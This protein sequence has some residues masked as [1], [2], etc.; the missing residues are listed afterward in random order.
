MLDSVL[1][2]VYGPGI[3]A[4]LGWVVQE[5]PAFAGMLLYFV[6]SLP[7]LSAAQRALCL[8]FLLHYG[9]RTFIF[10][11]RIRGG[12]PLPALLVFTA[13]SFCTCNGYL[14]GKGITGGASTGA[15]HLEGTSWLIDPRFLVGGVVFLC[16]WA[17]NLQADAILRDLRKPVGSLALFC[18]L[19]SLHLEQRE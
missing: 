19:A 15:A 13:F 5:L 11:L 10:P 1:R 6:A 17:L 2:V 3:N 7:R 12:K 8:L 16:G 14:Q 18:S 9:N 4:A